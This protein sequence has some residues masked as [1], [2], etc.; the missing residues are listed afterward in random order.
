[1]WCKELLRYFGPV[2]KFVNITIV[3]MCEKELVMSEIRNIVIKNFRAIKSLDWCPSPGINCL[4]GHGD[5]GK[6][7][8]IDAIDKCLTPRRYLTVSDADFHNLETQEPIVIQITIGKLPE[9]FLNFDKYGDYLRGFNLDSKSIDDEPDDHLEEVLT[10]RL[11]ID[12]DLEANWSLF[13]ERAQEKNLS[14]KEKILLSPLNISSTERSH[15]KLQQGSILNT[16]LGNELKVKP[17]FAE[18]G[19]RIREDFRK[20]ETSEVQTLLET[21]SI[22]AKSLGV[23]IGGNADIGVDPSTLLIKDNKL[24]LLNSDQ[25]PLHSL[26]TGSTR[27]L[28][29]GLHKN[30]T[31]P[32]KLILIDEVEYGLEPHRLVRFLEELGSKG[33][34]SQVFMSTHSPVVIQELNCQQLFVV[35]RDAVSHEVKQIDKDLQRFVRSSPEAF[36]AE[37]IIC[38]EGKSELGLL[39]GIDLFTTDKKEQSMFAY[40]VVPIDCGG[41][42]NFINIAEKLTNYGYTTCVY[43]DNDLDE[44]SKFL[45]KINRVRHKGIDVFTYM[46]NINLESALYDICDTKDIKRIVTLSKGAGNSELKKLLKEKNYLTNKGLNL[47]SERDQILEILCQVKKA[48]PFGVF[49]CIGQEIV[50][51]KL[52]LDQSSQLVNVVSDIFEWVRNLNAK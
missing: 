20:T 27:L 31:D 12:S 7:T 44:Q 41:G 22:T 4:I 25:I 10:V 18:I 8:I 2:P 24:C 28:I 30:S 3:G 6:S 23:N 40:G 42:D 32:N 17:I 39:R 26:G 37:A 47:P 15:F 38:C 13:S 1:M 35:H 33:D 16:I 50:G 11:V 5:V 9:Q 45:K 51:P 48:V 52:G 49:K 46:D 21:V 34:G 43:C 29:S 14:W 19:R 36:L